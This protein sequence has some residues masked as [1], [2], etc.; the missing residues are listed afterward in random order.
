MRESPFPVNDDGQCVVAKEV[1][2]GE[3]TVKKCDVCKSQKGGYWVC[4]PC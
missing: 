4:P 1:K 3:D 2:L